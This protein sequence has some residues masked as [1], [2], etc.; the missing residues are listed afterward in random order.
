ME[1]Y[2][3]EQLVKAW[4][5]YCKNVSKNPELFNEKYSKDKKGAEGSVDYLLSLVK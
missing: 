2:T 4:V 1:T 3:R 5:K